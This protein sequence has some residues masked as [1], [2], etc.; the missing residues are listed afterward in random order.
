MPSSWTEFGER[1]LELG[2]VSPP[3]RSELEGDLPPR[4]RFEVV[5]RILALLLGLLPALV[6]LIDVA[7]AVVQRNSE[8]CQKDTAK[9]HPTSSGARL[10]SKWQVLF[11]AP[12]ARRMPK[13]ESQGLC[14]FPTRSTDEGVGRPRGP[15]RPVS[16]RAAHHQTRPNGKFAW[17][18]EQTHE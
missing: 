11:R 13:L 17:F 4:R 12:A 1:S 6:M 9:K 10:P 3:A 2:G 18:E 5:V 14:I 16:V 8:P 15:A 7:V